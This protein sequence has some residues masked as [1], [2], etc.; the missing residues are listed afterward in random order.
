M[1]WTFVYHILEGAPTSEIRELF[2]MPAFRRLGI[3]RQLENI[4][5]E[6][7]RDWRSERMVLF[8]N[9]ADATLSARAAARLFGRTSGYEWRWRQSVG[10]RLV[11]RGQK[12]L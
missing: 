11:A 12:K 5:C 2:V 6:R 7:G 1:G 4:A 8:F 3:G 10:P 9:E